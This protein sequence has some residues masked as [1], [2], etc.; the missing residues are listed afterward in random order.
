MPVL[1]VPLV[2]LA[3]ASP[4]PTIRNT[5]PAVRSVKRELVEASGQNSMHSVIKSMDGIS[6]LLAR[7]ARNSVFHQIRTVQTNSSRPANPAVVAISR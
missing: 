5:H 7:A 4:H 1:C 3:C 2:A 6:S